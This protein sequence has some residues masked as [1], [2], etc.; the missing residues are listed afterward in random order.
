VAKSKPKPKAEPKTKAPPVPAAPA[1]QL[2]IEATSRFSQG[3]AP[4]KK[5]NKDMT[6]LQSVILALSMGRTLDRRYQDH[7]LKGNLKGVRDCHI[8]NDWVLLYRL[9]PDTLILIATGTHSDLGWT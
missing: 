8:E 5:R 7:A 9:E 1:R 6:K 2:E 3:V 4:Q